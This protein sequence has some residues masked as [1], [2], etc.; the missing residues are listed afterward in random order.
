[1]KQ[2]YAQ[3]KSMLVMLMLWLFLGGLGVHRFYLGHKILGIAILV[4]G[5]AG[6]FLFFSSAVTIFQTYQVTGKLVFSSMIS[7][8]LLTI[9]HFVW[10]M[11]D[12]VYI[13]I[14]KLVSG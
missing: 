12:G 13:V 2:P 11:F 4:I 7:Y 9:I 3:D 14:R 5:T 10:V 1:M 6:A 8:A